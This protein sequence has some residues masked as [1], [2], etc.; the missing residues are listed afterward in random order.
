MRDSA[1]EVEVACRADDVEY[2]S[3]AL[4]LLFLKWERACKGFVNFIRH[5]MEKADG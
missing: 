4:P 2:A 5:R 1:L 3:T